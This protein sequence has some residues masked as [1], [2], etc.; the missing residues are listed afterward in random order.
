LHLKN[1]YLNL[2]PLEGGCTD[3]RFNIDGYLTLCGPRQ[4]ETS[5]RSYC[6]TYRNGIIESVD[7]DDLKNRPDFGGKVIASI[8]YE[9]NII[10]AVQRHLQAYQQLELDPPVVVML[11]MLGVQG[12][13]MAVSARL[14]HFV[15]EIDRSELLVPEVLIEDFATPVHQLLK[16]I[17]DAVWNAT[18]FE[19]SLNYDEE[20][21]WTKDRQR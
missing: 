18:G 8:A 3:H 7:A 11:S 15:S 20:G 9:E 12:Y 10:H 1:Q 21:N 14:S 4:G 13:K 16:P 2:L 5:S 6:Q 19:N 17:F